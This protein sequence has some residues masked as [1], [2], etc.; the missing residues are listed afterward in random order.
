MLCPGAYSYEWFTADKVGE[1]HLFCSQ[2]CGTS[3]AA[4]IGTVYVME[5]GAYAKWAASAA[6]E[7]RPEAAGEHLF[8][9]YGCINC[10][11]SQAPS[12]A[13]IY[14]HSEALSDGSHVLVDEG[15]LRESIVNSRAKIVV[16]YPPIMPS[17]QGQLS[18][19]QLNQ[20]IA[21]I[22]SLAG[23]RKGGEP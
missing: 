9:Q 23:A 1:Y 16:G 22:K 6:P 17:Y 20:L 2:Y 14:G 3:H 19:E 4:M 15:Y 7:D 13:G 21:Y 12:L 8:T 5:P 11:G 18:E 10:H